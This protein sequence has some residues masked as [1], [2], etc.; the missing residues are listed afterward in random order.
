MHI[1]SGV[2]KG[3]CWLPSSIVWDLIRKSNNVWNAAA[4]SDFKGSISLIS[5][6]YDDCTVGGFPQSAQ[7]FLK[8]LINSCGSAWVYLMSRVSLPLWSSIFFSADSWNVDHEVCKLKLVSF[9]CFR[10]NLWSWLLLYE[11]W[12]YLWNIIFMYWPLLSSPVG[13][14]VFNVQNFTELIICITPRWVAGWL[15]LYLRV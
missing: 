13:T 9:K 15:K 2:S 5:F 3:L 11:L 7:S 8:Y 10:I 12:Y 1:V 14:S 4:S 6:L